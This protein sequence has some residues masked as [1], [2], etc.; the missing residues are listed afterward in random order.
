[1]LAGV[2]SSTVEVHEFRDGYLPHA[3]AAVKDVFEELKS[4]VD[5]D[6]VLTHTRDDLHQDHRLVCELTWNTF[7]DHLILE[8]EIPKW[9]GDLGRPN[10]YVPLAEE[11]VA[12]KLAHPRRAVRKPAEQGLVRPRG[13]PRADA[14]PGDGMPLAERLR[15]GLL[16]EEADPHA[17]SGRAVVRVLVTGSAGYIGSVL[18]PILAG[19]GHDVVGLDTGFYDGCDFGPH[20]NSERRIERDIRDV[21]AGEL[22]GFDAIVHLAALSNDPLGDLSRELTYDINFHA[23]VSLA[24]AAKE[25]GVARFVFAS[26]CSMYGAQEGDA[27]LT[28]D[29]PLRP[30]TP[31]AESKVRAEEALAE[32]AGDGFTPVSMRN[33]TVYGAVVASPARHRAEQPRSVEPRHGTDSPPERRDVMAPAAPRA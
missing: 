4:T 1:M 13:V 20:L 16:R 24:R 9:D 3:S 23:T 15:R 10:V 28:E 18:T 14:A 26:S 6:V 17:R 31:Y 19:A 5:P 25:G 11:H 12:R 7:R 30:L 21:G 22:E 8:Y 33:A 2:G 27:F 29:A 32:L